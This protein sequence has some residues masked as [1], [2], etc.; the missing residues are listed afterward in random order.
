MC[1]CTYVNDRHEWITLPS[2]S[3]SISVSTLGEKVN[4]PDASPAPHPISGLP[5]IPPQPAPSLIRIRGVYKRAEYSQDT[6]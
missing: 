1:L 6:H 5:C 2:Q 3:L 4:L